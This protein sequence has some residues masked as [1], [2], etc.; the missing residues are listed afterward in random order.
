[1]DIETTIIALGYIGIFLMMIANGAVSFPSS[2]ILYIICGYF[3][4]TGD[5][6]IA[7]VVFFG[8]L[9]NTIG[10]IILYE[11]VR[12]KGLH[13]IL[14]WKLFPKKEIK[15]IVVALGKKG[16]WFLFVGKLL[17]AIKVFVP[18]AAGVGK[19]RREIFIPIMLVTSAI[20]TAP[21][22]AIGFY[23][24]KSSD[25]FGKYAIVLAIVA[26]VVAGLFYK[27][28]NSKEVLDEIED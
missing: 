8:A 13:Y 27:Y 15:K 18:V 6:N 16:V 26:L 14:K 2:Q 20:W 23:F 3:V 7:L 5:L 28:I 4:F 11:V 9:G 25:L 10:C 22:L 12:F 1:M 21:F 19:T 24:G 17:P